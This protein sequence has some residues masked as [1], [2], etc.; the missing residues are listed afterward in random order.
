MRDALSDERCTDEAAKRIVSL[1]F[2]DKVVVASPNDPESASRAFRDGYTVVHGGQFSSSEWAT[3]RRAGAIPASSLATPSPKPFSADGKPLRLIDPEKWTPEVA[4]FARY[5]SKVAEAIL[6]VNALRVMITSDVGWGFGGA[7]SKGGQ[8]YV[9]LG[10]LGHA[11]FADFASERMNQFLIHEFGHE[12]AS[13]HM[14]DEYHDALCR[15]GAKLSRLALDSPEIFDA[16][17]YEY[18]CEQ[19]TRAMPRLR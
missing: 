9:N 13:D 10:R 2:G 5:A 16:S 15:L 18:D 1:R 17:H 6:R 12:H 7:Y 4:R 8:L 19:H 3:V 11:W 14:S